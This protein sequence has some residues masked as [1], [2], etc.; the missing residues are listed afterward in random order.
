MLKENMLTSMFPLCSSCSCT[1]KQTCEQIHTWAQRY[2]LDPGMIMSVIPSTLDA[3]AGGSL[4]NWGQP[5]LHRKF[6]F[7]PWDKLMLCFKQ[8]S[9]TNTLSFPLPCLGSEAHSLLE[10]DRL[11]SRHK[12]SLLGFAFSK[13][14][15]Q[16]NEDDKVPY[17]H[18]GSNS[19]RTRDIFAFLH[20]SRNTH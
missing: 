9:K 20:P 17:L 8:T 3:E 11:Q 13:T 16:G 6:K 15:F 1:L 7:S 12:A 2:R 14:S 10:W 18:K 5:G 4:R 19:W